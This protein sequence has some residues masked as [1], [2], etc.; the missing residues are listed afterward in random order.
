M[1][2]FGRKLAVGFSIPVLMLLVIGTVSHDST[3]SL[4]E[5]SDWVAHTHKVLERIAIVEQLAVQ[6]ED[7]HRGYAL[8]GAEVFLEPARNA[9][10]DL[11]ATQAELRELTNDNPIQQRHLDEVFPLIKSKVDWS[12]KLSDTRRAQGLQ[13]AAD[14]AASQRGV[15]IMS[16]VHRITNEMERVERTLLVEREAAAKDTA[17]RAKSTILGGTL[18]C[19]L[20]A[21]AAGYVLTRS[22]TLQVG[23]AVRHIQ[24][25]SAELQAAANQQVAGTREPRVRSLIVRNAWRK[26][27]ATPEAPRAKETRR[28]NARRNRSWRSSVR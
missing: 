2:T 28:Y 23:S 18:A 10:S 17:G 20:M 22:L 25:S 4:T 9:A 24:S 12:T 8:G 14:L 11:D 21:V 15:E 26:S 1:W 7:A 16:A 27:R 13:A 3:T 5:T 19:L 6:I